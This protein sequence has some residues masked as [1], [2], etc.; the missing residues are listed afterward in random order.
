MYGLRKIHRDLDSVR[1]RINKLAE[2]DRISLVDAALVKGDV[3]RLMEK[4][5]KIIEAG[6]DGSEQSGREVR[7]TD[8]R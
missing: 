6:R 7:T 1:R 3:L 4:V 8:E 5:E 2:M